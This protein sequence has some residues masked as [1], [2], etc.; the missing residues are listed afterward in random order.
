MPLDTCA[1]YEPRW[2]GKVVMMAAQ[3]KGQLPKLCLCAMKLPKPRD[4]QHTKL[5]ASCSIPFAMNTHDSEGL[6]QQPP[7]TSAAH[8]PDTGEA[9][10]A[11]AAWRRYAHLYAPLIAS[12]FAVFLSP[13][14]AQATGFTTGGNSLP[15]VVSF[16]IPTYLV[17][18]SFYPSNRPEP[19]PKQ[20]IRFTRKN[21]LYRAGVI[22]TYGRLFGTPPNVIQY[23]VDILGS[24]GADQWIGERPV[25]TRQRRSEFLIALTWILGSWFVRFFVSFDTPMLQQI[26]PLVDRILN[27]TAYVALVDDVV[28]VLTRPNLRT[29]KGKATLIAT[30]AFTISACVFLFM[31]W[32]KGLAEGEV[33]PYLVSATEL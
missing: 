19:T 12:P 29:K 8:A 9:D 17:A 6:P 26:V 10:Y 13:A 24:Y 2:G 32:A 20:S 16:A 14:I 21:D 31:R 27:L 25:G 1:A 22:A 23:L 15:L 5:T 28:G 33:S 7:T 30:Q 3:R 4:A 18:S 11:I